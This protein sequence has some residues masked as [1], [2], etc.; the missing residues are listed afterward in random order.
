MTTRQPPPCQLSHDIHNQLFVIRAHCEG[1]DTRLP[2]PWVTELTAKIRNA[3]DRI[4]DLL[5]SVEC[6]TP[7]SHNHQVP[8]KHTEPANR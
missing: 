3:L 8:A 5:Q 4:A 2:S 6:N 7:D 1:L